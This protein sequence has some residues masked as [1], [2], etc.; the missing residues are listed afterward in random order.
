MLW[1]FVCAEEVTQLSAIPRSET[2]R[3]K[4]DFIEIGLFVCYVS[5]TIQLYQ[6]KQLQKVQNVCASF[7]LGRY[8]READSL[9]LGWLP[10]ADRRQFQVLLSAFKALYFN[11]WPEYIKVD[12][13]VPGRTLRSS[14]QIQLGRSN[15]E[16]PTESGTFQDSAAAAFNLFCEICTVTV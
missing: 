1:S 16:V 5:P 13:Y 8:A 3:R 9:Q 6:Q 10:V 2:S 12:Q 4:P 7:V 11:N 15:L 14:S